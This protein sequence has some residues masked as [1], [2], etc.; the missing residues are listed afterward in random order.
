MSQDPVARS[1]ALDATLE[2][3]PVVTNLVELSKQHGRIIK[4][5]IRFSAL[6]AALLIGVV[7]V[8]WQAHE[9]ANTAY[10]ASSQTHVNCLS[11]NQA[12]A[13]Q[14][15]L[16]TFI[17]SFPPPLHETAAAKRRRIHETARFKVFV[18]KKFAPLDC[19]AVTPAPAPSGQLP[20]P[21]PSAKAS[22]HPTPGSTAAGPPAPFP[23]PQPA[24]AP[25]TTARPRPTHRPPPQPSHSPR[26]SPTA[27]P[28]PSP[29]KT[30]LCLPVICKPVQLVAFVVGVV[31][32]LLW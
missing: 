19:T 14:R 3:N 12:R 31:R 18:H 26:P 5:M 10:Q 6:G 24:P 2:Q 16:W 7:Y 13:T 17:L 25:T 30:P 21:P 4:W 28:T 29:T 20:L 1:D 11:A 9:A 23:P 15:Q 8:A 22:A 32:W 27:H